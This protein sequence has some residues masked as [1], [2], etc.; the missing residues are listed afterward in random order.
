MIGL[1]IMAALAMSAVAAGSASAAHQWLIGHAAITSPVTIHSHGLLLL[2]DTKAT[3]G[4]VKVHC[5]G[6][7]VGTV[8]PGALDLVTKVTLELLGTKKQIACNIDTAGQCKQPVTAE[9]VNLPWH[10]ELTLIT[11]GGIPTVRDMLMSSGAGNPGWAVTCNTILGNVTDTC[12]LALGHTGVQNVSTGVNAIFDANSP[13]ANC[14]QGG[15][16]TGV[17]RGT[18]SLLSPG[19]GLSNLLTFD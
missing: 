1:A 12:T 13:N 9:A 14:S 8:G 2:E 6:H 17:V 10:T 19:A 3:G 15:A 11:L 16:G 5:A 7:D 4:A 18:V